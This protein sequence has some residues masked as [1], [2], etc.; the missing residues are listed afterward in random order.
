MHHGRPCLRVL[1]MQL[2]AEIIMYRKLEEDI[3]AGNA[4]AAQA[5]AAASVQ[6][7][8]DDLGEDALDHLEIKDHPDN[9]VRALQMQEC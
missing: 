5:S 7:D 8:F 2:V 1:N 3:A 9:I 4:A 6:D